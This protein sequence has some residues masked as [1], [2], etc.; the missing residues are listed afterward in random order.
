MSLEGKKLLVLGGTTAS[1]DLIK[2][3]REMG[4][5]T[6]VA[7]ADTPVDAVSQI[8][9]ECVCVST[10][11]FCALEELVREKRIDGVFCGPSEF[12]I[13]NLLKLCEQIGLPCYTTTEVWN[14][15]AN[16]DYF[17]EYCCR[18][19]VDCP[20]EFLVSEDSDDEELQALPFPIIV[21]PV[22]ASSSAG[23][24]TCFDWTTVREACRFARAAS[25]RGKII[26]EKFIENEG[27]IFSVRYLL[28]DGEAY[29]YFLMDTYVLDADSSKGLISHLML[30]PS[31][32]TEYY[33]TEVDAKMRQMLKG[34]GLTNGTAF[35]QALPCD[36]KIC[37]HE[38][39]YRLS[40]GMIFKL[41]QPLVGI[42]DMKMMIALALGEELY[43]KAEMDSVDLRFDK[44][45][46]Q[47]MFPLNAGK[48][49]AI[50]GLD[51]IKNLP[52]V[53]DF[54]QYYHVG[55]MVAE[56]VLGTLG[57]HFGRLTMVFEDIHQAEETI[58]FVQQTLK[59]LG[60]N[61]ELL[62]AHPFDFSRVH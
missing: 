29:P 39:G 37:F 56:K 57:Q 28:K 42:N 50:H 35:L 60:E 46:V 36:G 25:K 30:A 59:V 7:S 5:Y 34:M 2:N 24:T 45:G 53:V 23:I 12:N 27:N 51:E 6:V 52:E 55:D 10:V 14:H 31:K 9:D 8:A 48:I 17:K 49:T 58:S 18:Y 61:D 20:D 16:K 44:L 22:D 33:L 1:L 62:N 3:A 47:L 4:V 32:Y 40:G 15:C 19:G 41:T 26:V 43:S 11:D 21:K 38:M 13:R 54:L